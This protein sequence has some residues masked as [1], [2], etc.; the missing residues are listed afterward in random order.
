MIKKTLTAAT[1]ALAL[2]VG[3]ALAKT[4]PSTGSTTTYRTITIDGIQVFYRETGPQGAP[5]LLLH[6]FP[7]SSRMFDTLIL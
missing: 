2:S 4:V 5:T 7:S 3:D 1:S 6:G